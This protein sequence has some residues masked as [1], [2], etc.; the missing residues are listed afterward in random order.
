MRLSITDASTSVSKWKV[1]SWIFITGI[2]HSF[3][4]NFIVIEGGIYSSAQGL[5]GMPEIEPGLT[6]CKASFYQLVLS[7]F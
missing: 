1:P 5:D 7:F 3:T 4:N 2:L 6:T